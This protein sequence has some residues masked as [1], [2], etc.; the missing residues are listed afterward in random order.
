MGYAF[1]TGFLIS[2]LWWHNAKTAA[3]ADGRWTAVVFGLGAAT[4]TV[5][6]ASLARLL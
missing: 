3:H 2:Y 1:V 6:G 5:V 4:G